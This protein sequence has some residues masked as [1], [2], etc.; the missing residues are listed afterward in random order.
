MA[1]K[2]KLDERGNCSSC[3]NLSAQKEHVKCFSCNGL[4]H[5][6]CNSATSDE[7]PATK[8]TISDNRDGNQ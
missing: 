8:T 6:V 7:K 3:G 4:F 5:V 2:F 1:E